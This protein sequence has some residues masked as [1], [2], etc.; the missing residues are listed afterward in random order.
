MHIYVY[1]Y[2]RESNT[3]THPTPC[4][5]PHLKAHPRSL[6]A[7]VHSIVLVPSPSSFHPSSS[8]TPQTPYYRHPYRHPPRGPRAHFRSRFRCKLFWN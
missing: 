8:Q 3:H 2:I 1:P 5:P 7:F 4:L 6:P